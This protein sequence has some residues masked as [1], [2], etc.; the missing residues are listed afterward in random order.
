[1]RSYCAREMGKMK[2]S[3]KS[4]SGIDEVYK[5][6]W[7]YFDTLDSFL[8]PHATPRKS[9]SNLVSFSYHIPLPDHLY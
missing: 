2:R 8:R 4:G 9:V 3:K 5:S 1:M 6:K 7:A